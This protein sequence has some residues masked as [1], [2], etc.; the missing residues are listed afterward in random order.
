M[1]A[2]VER[3]LTKNIRTKVAFGALLAALVLPCSSFAASNGCDKED[4]D[5]INPAIALCSTHVYNIGRTQNQVNEAN[6]Q[7]MRD[8][9]ALK[10]TIITQQMQQQYDFLEA[11]LKRLKTQLEKAVLTTKFEAAGASGSSS[12]SS[13]SNDKNVVLMGAENCLLKGSI[14]DGVACVQNNVRIILNAVNSGDIGDAYRQLQKDLTFA[15]NFGIVKTSTQDGKTIYKNVED[16]EL[17]DCTSL[18]AKRDVVNNCAYQLNVAIMLKQE[19]DSKKS[20]SPSN[21]NIY[22]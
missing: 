13:S 7:V 21:Y 3:F 4:Y 17:T 6:K 11:T 20:S 18:S 9:V 1:K 8:V 14:S 2:I 19:A 15:G 10:T 16:S 22:R 12:G 5:R